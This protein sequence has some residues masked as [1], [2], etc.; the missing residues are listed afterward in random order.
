M[1]KHAILFIV[2]N[3]LERIEDFFKIYDHRF[4]YFVHIDKK[5]NI[6][7]D[8]IRKIKSKN[9][10]V[11]YIGSEYTVNWGGFN[12]LK[13]IIFLV[14]KALNY[15]GFSYIH[16]TSESNLPIKSNSF[17]IDFFNQNNGRE[18]IEHFPLESDKWFRG[19]LYRFNLYN[20]Y[21]FFNAKTKIGKVMINKLLNFQDFIGVNRNILKKIPNL[22]GGSCWFSLTS[23]CL[24]FC[25]NYINQNPKFI[26]AFQYSHCPEEAF[27]QTIII[28]SEFRDFVV[29]DHL[30]YID[31]EFRNG[32]S[33]ANLDS[34][35]LPK[36]LNS[37]KLT[38]RKIVP[39]VSDQ[40]R[41]DILN[42]LEIKP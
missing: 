4:Y 40:V 8:R 29:N 26:K 32:N 36:L 5:C 15:G 10:N 38:A 23:K 3:N 41:L 34:S 33:P 16:T 27:F 7:P 19:G 9:E 35:D 37:E 14:E 31:W 12:F 28:N 13:T 24:E 42:F 6:E 2:H 18:F 1:E 22:Y 30:N 17:F 21:D 25:L 20:L 11:V 39:G